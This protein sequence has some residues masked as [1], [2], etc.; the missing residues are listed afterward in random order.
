RGQSG[1]WVW[2]YKLVQLD[3]PISEETDGS[4]LAS[5]VEGAAPRVSSTIQRLVRSTRVGRQVKHLHNYTCQFCG[6][7]LDTPAGPYAEAAHIRPLGRPHDGP[8][9]PAN[10]L[11]LCPNCHVRFDGGG[12]FI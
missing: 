9:D 5:G 8:D 6:V 11:C 3:D 2:R 4:S 10:V 12:L 7:R 1:Y